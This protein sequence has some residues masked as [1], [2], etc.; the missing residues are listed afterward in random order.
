MP[1][2]RTVAA[3]L[4]ARPV[5]LRVTLIACSAMLFTWTVK[6]ESADR[7]LGEE[8]RTRTDM[9]GWVS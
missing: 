4:S 8:A 5:P 9:E 1:E 3:A 7:P 2:L 6:M